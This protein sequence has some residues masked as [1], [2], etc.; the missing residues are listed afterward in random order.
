MTNVGAQAEQIAAQYLQ[1]Q[2]LKL[3]AKNYR[4]RFG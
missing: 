3:I 4:S 1:R 2:G